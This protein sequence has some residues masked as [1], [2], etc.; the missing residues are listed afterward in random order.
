MFAADKVLSL[1]ELLERVLLN[2][3]WRDLFKILRI[4]KT[5]RETVV[6]HFLLSFDSIW[7]FC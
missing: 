4:N 3:G 7:S 5:F 6:N 2:L 1:P